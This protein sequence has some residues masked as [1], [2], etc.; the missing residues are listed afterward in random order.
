MM[1]WANVLCIGIFIVEYVIG[2]PNQSRICNRHPGQP[3]F[4][5]YKVENRVNV[6]NFVN[7]YHLIYCNDNVLMY[8]LNLNESIPWAQALQFSNTALS[9]KLNRVALARR[10]SLRRIPIFLPNTLVGALYYEDDTVIGFSN[11]RSKDEEKE[12]KSLFQ[13]PLK[14]IPLV[15]DSFL[16]YWMEI[17]MSLDTVIHIPILSTPGIESRRFK[18]EFYENQKNGDWSKYI[19]A[20]EAYSFDY[21]SRIWFRKA[22]DRT[23]KLLN[24]Y[25]KLI[26][27]KFKS[28][29]DEYHNTYE[30]HD[31]Q[32]LYKLVL[33]SKFIPKSLF[34]RLLTKLDSILTNPQ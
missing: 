2:A 33:I 34:S 5:G 31:A 7:S 28:L 22:L 4:T 10:K 27:T 3:S 25:S 16:D 24:T 18:P 15:A 13:V 14:S 17:N 21:D 8:D 6:K 12:V 11:S 26:P 20:S 1:G 9:S 19:S 32:F 30:E 29:K 23:L